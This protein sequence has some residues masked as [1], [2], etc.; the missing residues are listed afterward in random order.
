MST[1][2]NYHKKKIYHLWM[3]SILLLTCGFPYF[4]KE[5]DELVSRYLWLNILHKVLFFVFGVMI[6]INAVK[7]IPKSK[8]AQKQ[9]AEH[10]KKN[11][12]KALKITS[13]ICFGLLTTFWIFFDSIDFLDGRTILG[14]ILYCTGLTL[15]GSF[16]IL[17]RKEWMM[18][19]KTK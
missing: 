5:V 16:L 19:S 18:D 13:V 4:T 2:L 14:I 3:Y 11:H 9:L 10:Q 15:L 8:K 17:Y 1:D 12:Y 6:F 7:S